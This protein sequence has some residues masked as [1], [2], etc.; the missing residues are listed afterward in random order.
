MKRI[1]IKLLVSSLFMIVLAACSQIGKGDDPL[2]GTSW[3]LRSLGSEGIVEG[4]NPTLEFSDGR[5]SGS[6]GCNSMGGDY[7]VNDNQL[8]I[9]ELEMTLMACLDPEGLMAQEQL[10][11]QALQQV[12]SFDLSVDQLSFVTKGGR[13]LNFVRTAENK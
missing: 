4:T 1:S 8:V 6:A 10:Y 5:V 3:E 9:Q 12:D 11:F 7:Q 13:T 2:N